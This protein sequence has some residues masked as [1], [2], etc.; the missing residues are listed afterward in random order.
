MFFGIFGILDNSAF[1][2]SV[3]K[4]RSQFI[5]NNYQALKAKKRG[6]CVFLAFRPILGVCQ[7][8]VEAKI[9]VFSIEQ[10]SP[11]FKVNLI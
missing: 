11:I 7:S 6:F 2:Y 10:C 8:K 5:P 1:Y 9:V 4:W 3:E